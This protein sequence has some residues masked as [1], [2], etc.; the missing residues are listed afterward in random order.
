[1]GNRIWR[2][3]TEMV[4]DMLA[5]TNHSQGPFPRIIRGAWIHKREA[6]KLHN[7]P[8]QAL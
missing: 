4:M 1:M 2:M 8:F 5:Q 3:E 6:E 7:Y